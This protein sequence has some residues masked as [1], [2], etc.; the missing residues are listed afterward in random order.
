MKITEYKIELYFLSGHYDILEVH[1]EKVNDKD[2]YL[3]K[4]G[5]DRDTLVGSIVRAMTKLSDQPVAF[6]VI[7]HT[8]L[9]LLYKW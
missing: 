2:F 4:Q 5:N 1:V 9:D 6:T 3:H 8:E 7:D